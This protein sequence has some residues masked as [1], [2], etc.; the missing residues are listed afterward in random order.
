MG[1]AL[2][3]NP[4]EAAGL[5]VAMG[6][7]KLRCVEACSIA[8][9]GA[10]CQAKLSREGHDAPLDLRV[11]ESVQLYPDD[12]VELRYATDGI[13]AYVCVE[14]GVDVPE[15]LGSRSTDLRAMM[16]G[17]AGRMLE[18]G[19]VIGSMDTEGKTRFS[20]LLFALV[21]CSLFLFF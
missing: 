7:L 5:E 2:L 15:V 19:D 11:N 3:G 13:R 16:G 12:V 18:A 1:N 14:G 20:R 21:R 4:E 6:G 9:T 10:D 8:L 17:V